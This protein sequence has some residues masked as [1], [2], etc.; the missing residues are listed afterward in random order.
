MNPTPTPI[1][2]Q[3]ASS[4]FASSH[5]LVDPVTLAAIVAIV[6]VVSIRILPIFARF[7]LLERAFGGLIQSIEYALRGAL[8]VVVVGLMI[9]PVYVVATSDPGTRSMILRWVGFA[10]AG[11]T[12]LVLLGWISEKAGAAFF[13]AH[14]EFDSLSD[15]LPDPESDESHTPESSD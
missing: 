8:S 7:R 14:P 15:A 9:S 1:G 4:S 12:T 5:N 11:Y 13:S 2:F 10:I 6:L 3:N